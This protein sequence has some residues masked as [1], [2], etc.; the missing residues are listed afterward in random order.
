MIA[1]LTQRERELLSLYIDLGSYELVAQEL[2]LARQ[3]VKNM[4][5]I[6]LRKLDV[7]NITQ[8]CVRYDRCMRPSAGTSLAAVS[9]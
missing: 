2:G 5:L 1:D 9:I 7:T 6:I 4:A 8:A 3:T